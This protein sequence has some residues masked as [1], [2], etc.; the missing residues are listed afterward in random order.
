LKPRLGRSMTLFC[1]P[2]IVTS[3]PHSYLFGPSVEETAA[4]LNVSPV[5][6]MRDWSR[7]RARLCRKLTGGTG[8]GS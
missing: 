6:M 4:V 8:D 2:A 3:T 1:E 7:G 5:T